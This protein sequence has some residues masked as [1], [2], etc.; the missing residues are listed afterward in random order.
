VAADTG[1]TLGAKILVVG[2]CA[3]DCS[4]PLSGFV[5]EADGTATITQVQD[6]AGNPLSL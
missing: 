4:T 5:T 2:Q 3:S 6:F 1:E